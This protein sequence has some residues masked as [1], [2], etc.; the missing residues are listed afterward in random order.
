M[1][2]FLK[3]LVILVVAT[4]AVTGCKKKEERS[5]V[6]RMPPH[7]MMEQKGT[8]IVVIPD[9][10]KGKWK[11]VKIAVAD[12]SS[13]KSTEYDV[14]IGKTFPIP[15]TDLVIIVENFLPDFTMDGNIRT[16]KSDE[17]KNPAAQVLITEKEK[18]VYKNWL[19]G[20]LKSPHAFQHP[21]YDITLVGYIPAGK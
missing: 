17:L 4:V 10:E 8:P 3:V 12:K 1:R 11:A 15:N 20:I 21:K 14:E 6:E 2:H 13:G 16:S 19:F 7:G 18:E 9:S 5:P